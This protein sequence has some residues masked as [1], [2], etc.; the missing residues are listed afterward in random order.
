MPSVMDRILEVARQDLLDL[1]ARNRLISTPRDTSRSKRLDIIDER[2]EE[3]FRLLVREKKS[4]TFLPGRGEEVAL[5][6]RD[7]ILPGL[8]QPDEDAPVADRH[9]DLR[10][11]TRLTSEGLQTRLLDLSCEARTAIE[12]QGVSILYLALG[13]LKWFEAPSSDKARFAPL[14]LIPVELERPSAASKFRLKFRDEEIATNL[15][16][17]AKLW[18][19]FQINLP[20]VPDI[21]ELSPQEY[22]DSVAKAIAVQPRWEVLQNDMALWFF[23]FAKY[24]MYRDLSPENWPEHAPLIQNRL[25]SS[26]LNDGF[27]DDPPLCSDQDKI[28]ELIPPEN[29][30]H[31]TDADSSQALVIEEVRRGRN[32]V[33][34]GPPGTGKSQTITN[35]IATAVKEGKRVLFVAEKLAALEVVKSRLDRVGLG[36]VCLELHSHRANKRDVLDEIGRT[37]NLGRPKLNGLPGTVDAVRNTRERLNQHA[38]LMNSPFAKSELAPFQ[39]LGRLVGLYAQGG[40]PVDFELPGAVEWTRKDFLEKC[41]LLQDF[42]IHLKRVGVPN[43]HP[44][45]G[46]RLASPPLP[47]DL[48]QWITRIDDMR[49]RVQGA[50]DSVH[51]LSQLLH[52]REQDSVHLRAA[53][54]LGRIVAKLLQ[55]PPMDRRQIADPIWESRCD[56][57]AELL[58]QGRTLAAIESRLAGVVSEIAWETDLTACRREVAAHGRSWLCWLR[59]GYREGIACLRGVMEVDIPGS[60]VER[61]KLIDTI[62]KAQKLRTLLDRKAD[63]AL[64]GRAAF[65]ENWNGARSNWSGLAAIVDWE[66]SCRDEKLPKSIRQIAARLKDAGACV[67]PMDRLNQCTERL[68]D[69]LPRLCTQMCVDFAEAFQTEAVELIPLAN[70]AARLEIWSANPESLSKWVAFSIREAQL[71]AI[72][73]GALL[74]RIRTGTIAG[75]AALP[76]FR[77]AYYEVLLRELFRTEPA[78]ATF[79]GETYEQCIAEFRKSDLERIGLAKLEVALAHYESIPKGGGLGDMA[80]VRREIEKKRNIMPIRKLLKEAGEAVQAIKPVFMMSPIS[81]AQFLEPGAL[82]FDLLLIDE[83]SQVSPVDAFGAIARA[84]QVVVVGDSKQLPPTRF[85]TKMLD[86]DLSDGEAISSAGDLESVLGLCLSRGVMPR[87]LQWN[88]RSRHHSLIAVSNRE[89]YENRLF[90]VPN[91]ADSD[92]ENGLRFRYVEGGVFDRGGTATNRLEASAIAQAVIEHARTSPGKSLGVGAFSVAQRDL[93]RDELELLQRQ[94][95]GADEFFTPRRPEPFFIKNLE[96]IQGD[97]RDVIFISVG[98]ARDASGFMAMNFGPLSTDGGERRLNVLISRARLRCEVFSSITAEDIDLD[99]GRSR[100]VAAFKTFLR[101]AKS[102]VLDERAPTGRSFD[103]DFERQVSNAL[104]GLGYKVDCQVGSSGFVI[105]LAVV[106]PNAPGRYVLGIECDGATYHS[107][108]AARD[109][110]RLRE[111]VLVDRGWK[112]HRIWSTDWFH[113]PKEQ[114]QKTVTAIERAL[115]DLKAA[116]FKEDAT[117]NKPLSATNAIQRDQDSTVAPDGPTPEWVVPY[118]EAEFTPPVWI[119]IHQASVQELGEVVRRVVSM[120]SPIHRDEIARRITSLCGLDRTGSR[121]SEAVEDAINW[122]VRNGNVTDQERFISMASQKNAPV[123]NR[124]SVASSSL[125]KPELIAPAEIRE[126]LKRLVSD[127]L[128]ARRDEVRTTVARVLG[129]KSTSAQLKETLDRQI[130]ALLQSGQMSERDDKLF[131]EKQEWGKPL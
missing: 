102:G 97:E 41:G 47:T 54:S 129:F 18:K 57:I 109:R 105:D 87:M 7:G 22:F 111:Q 63:S 124:Q 65:G 73:L 115:S 14:L 26:L 33:V 6:E 120:E 110:D 67:Q 48:Q 72:G 16:L 127:H 8:A 10:L 128:G 31:V 43:S 98:Y 52:V 112:I 114:L 100:G 99:R 19:E 85:F 37:M 24:L 125:R 4:F 13:F 60:H 89:F 69:G 126:A 117:Q 131:V 49:T 27:P 81:V 46:I 11:Q 122:L 45:R 21:D 121:I 118:A 88:Y 66:K 82:T 30:I 56:A 15:S 32:L 51:E 108:R 130:D 36:P 75:E 5:K 50:L 35:M 25:L 62:I 44:W 123:R 119:Q 96:N 78:L 71:R 93:I 39:L 34:Q 40:K 106:D 61:L 107:S 55:A 79:D 70:L 42:E 9:V 3:V 68:R 104:T 86:D 76:Q 116:G 59:R 12:E 74:D 38:K 20:D 1:S 113:R 28:D 80:V 103:S 53:Q 23:S 94:T 83:A 90:V 84:T 29:M 58:A 91:P 101:F 77:L 64:L 95:R 92:E 2:S 17:K